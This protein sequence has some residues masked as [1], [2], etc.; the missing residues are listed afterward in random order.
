MADIYIDRLK[1][2][3]N[4]ACPFPEFTNMESGDIGYIDFDGVDE[5]TLIILTTSMER[6][7]VTVHSGNGIQ[8]VK[9]NEFDFE[10]LKDEIK[11]LVLESGKYK[12]V[13]DKKGKVKIT[14]DGSI[15]VG[16]IELA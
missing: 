13:L 1:I 10:I 2:K 15:S 9:V 16:V 8:G 6:A 7:N 12:D 11:T 3:R 14:A 5:K 4:E